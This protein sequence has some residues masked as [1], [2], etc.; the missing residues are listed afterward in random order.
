MYDLAPPS[1]KYDEEGAK[2][3]T[4]SRQEDQ[5]LVSAER[6]S[7]RAKRL[8]ASSHRHRRDRYNTFVHSLAKEFKD[9][10]VSRAFTLK[11]LAK[12]K[13]H[14]FA[15]CKVVSIFCCFSI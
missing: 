3:R 14:W 10:T 5:N 9:Q 8:T 15:H 4:F 13:Q 11:R 1:S 12:E 6:S 7:D 2:L